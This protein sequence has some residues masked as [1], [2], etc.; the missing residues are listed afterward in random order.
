MTVRYLTVVEVLC[1]HADQIESYGGSSGVR[2]HGQLESA[3]FRPQSGYCADV[4]AEAAA[5]WESLAQN[6]PFVDGNKRTA[7][8]ATVTFLGLNG[9][10]IT[11]DWRATADFIL[12][13]YDTKSFTFANLE[14]WLRASTRPV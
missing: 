8:A 13:L 11:A 7:V 14:P 2:D 5:L 12:G 10:D 3:L 4:L 9:Y 6:H 1:I